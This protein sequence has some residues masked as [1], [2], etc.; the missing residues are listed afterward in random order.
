M[1]VNAGIGGNESGCDFISDATPGCTATKYTYG[2]P[3]TSY[4][5]YVCVCF[6]D[7]C[8]RSAGLRSSAV[9]CLGII[10]AAVLCKFANVGQ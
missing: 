8:N 10:L 9:C 7:L 6:T 2:P 5:A 3:G 4:P 1:F